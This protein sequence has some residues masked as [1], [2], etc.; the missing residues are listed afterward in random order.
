VLG[1]VVWGIVGRQEDVNLK[2]YLRV[3]GRIKKID[4]NI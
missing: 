4:T 1:H 3:M 2:H